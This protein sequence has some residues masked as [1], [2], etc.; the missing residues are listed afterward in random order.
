MIFLIKKNKS[1][2]KSVY[3]ELL[4]EPLTCFIGHVTARDQQEVGGV[5]KR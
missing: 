1:H 4:L 3:L 5:P 2:L